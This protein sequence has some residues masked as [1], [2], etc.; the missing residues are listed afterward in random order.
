MVVKQGDI[1]WVDLGDPVGSAPGFLHP[2]VV[3]QND[4][5]NQFCILSI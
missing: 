1:Y 5:F 2:H 3:I 4:A